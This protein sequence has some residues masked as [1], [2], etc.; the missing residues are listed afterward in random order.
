MSEPSPIALDLQRALLEL[1]AA[2][3]SFFL[4]RIPESDAE[5][6]LQ[7]C[8]LR[9]SRGLPG[10]QDQNRLAAW[11]FQIARRLVIDYWRAHGATARESSGGSTLTFLTMQMSYHHIA[12]GDLAGE[13]WMVSF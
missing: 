3:R 7:E 12:Q 8:Y 9:V 13:P 6:L 1:D 11:V 2:L 4:R 10:L 5:D